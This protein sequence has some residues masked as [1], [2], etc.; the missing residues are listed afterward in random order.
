MAP[1]LPR[2]L[3]KRSNK[4][5]KSIDFARNSITTI[6]QSLQAFS[7]L[8]YLDLSYNLI[9]KIEHLEHCTRLQH[10]NLSHN[11]I[12]SLEGINQ[13]V[14][15]VKTLDISF[16]RLKSLEGLTKCGVEVL[17]VS[18]NLIQTLA[19]AKQVGQLP[20]VRA[21][22]F[23]GNPLSRIVDYRVKMLHLFGERCHELL[24]DNQPSLEDELDRV[25]VLIA[26]QQANLDVTSS[27]SNGDH[28]VSPR[29]SNSSF[30][31]I[32]IGSQSA[33]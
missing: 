8:I 18:N 7:N 20:L 19:D 21:I 12:E 30:N 17:D 10:L 26:L 16:N 27:Q 23:I 3:E 9:E 15:N 5:L 1:F 32:S 25:A 14:G 6:D 31:R 33:S 29:I 4:T 2:E 28:R 13:H 24:I 11:K 22:S